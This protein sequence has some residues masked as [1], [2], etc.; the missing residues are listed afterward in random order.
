MLTVNPE[1]MW[2]SRW[3]CGILFDQFFLISKYLNYNGFI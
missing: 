2:I 3:F 1:V